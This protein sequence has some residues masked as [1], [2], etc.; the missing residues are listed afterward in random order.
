MNM[1]QDITLS[2]WFVNSGSQ[3]VR[4]WMSLVL[5]VLDSLNFEH[6]SPPVACH[7]FTFYASDSDQSH[8]NECLW[9]QIL[10]WFCTK[11]E[12]PGYLHPCVPYPGFCMRTGVTEPTKLRQQSLCLIWWLYLIMS[13]GKLDSTKVIL[14]LLFILIIIIYIMFFAFLTSY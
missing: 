9:M 12:K 10:S 4:L 5:S 11:D 6:R 8:F 1:I 2:S 14:S 3:S 13:N 7:V